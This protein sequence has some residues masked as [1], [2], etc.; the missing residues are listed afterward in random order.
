MIAN[1]L[2]PKTVRRLDIDHADGHGPDRDIGVVAN[3]GVVTARLESGHVVEIAPRGD[4][5]RVTVRGA[6]GA[7][8]LAFEIVVRGDEVVVRGN[9]AALELEAA[10]VVTSCET[11]TVDARADIHL[12]AGGAI[13]QTA[14]ERVRL[15]G[16]AVELEATR[17]AV[18]V[19]ANDDVQLLGEQVLLNCERPPTV[20]AWGSAKARPPAPVPRAAVSGD[21]DLARAMTETG[22]DGDGPR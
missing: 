16:R 13:L 12:R 19:R 1:M 10:H 5:A 15:Q 6:V 17:G 3:D 11:F 18:R 22:A 4:A 21:E 20:P 8:K 9:A 7:E 2:A 14:N